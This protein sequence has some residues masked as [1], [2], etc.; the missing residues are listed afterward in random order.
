MTPAAEAAARRRA[1]EEHQLGLAPEP[2]PVRELGSAPILVSVF[3]SGAVL[4]GVEL[5]ASRVLAPFFGNSL[6][7][8]G[9]IIGV[10]LGGLSVGYWLGGVVGDLRPRPSSLLAA[11]A[12]GALTVLTIPV[13]DDPVIEQVL[14]WDPGPRLDPLLCALLLFG[15]MSIVLSAV[16]PIALRLRTQTLGRVGR[17]AGQTFAVST[18]GSIAGTFA[19]AFWLV[20]ELGTDQLFPLGAAV[21]CGTVALLAVALRAWVPLALAAAALAG[22]GAYAAWLGEERTGPLS[23]T[24]SKNWS[25][26]YRERGYG[27]LDA[28]DPGAD[29]VD[30]KLRVVFSEDTRYHRLSVVDDADTR[31]LRF[32]NS[33]QSAMWLRAPFRTRY[34]YTDFFHLGMAYNPSAR[35]VLYVGLGAGSSE[36]RLWRDFPAAQI[37]VVELDPVVVDVARRYFSLPADS[38][39]QVDVGDGRRFLAENTDRW[40]VIVIDAFFADAIPAHLVTREFLELARGRLAPGGVVVT[41]VI[42]ALDGP[43]SKLFRS[44]YKTYRTAFP[45]VLVHPAILPGDRGDSAYRNLIL[46][47]TEK[48]VPQPRALASRWDELRRAHPTAPDLRSPILDRRDAEIPTADVPVLTDDYAPTDAL[49][50]LF[51]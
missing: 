49:L 9:A 13:V 28:R 15:P 19:T 51:Q 36:K 44:V 23:A 11:L 14:A 39:L 35:R 31:Y 40:D 16:G 41:N 47:A 20:P 50:L 8:W 32:D 45:S 29:A 34:R 17:T 43:G 38:R 10:I 5:A 18:A 3:L 37:Q 4:L 1:R 21:L 7:V 30:P 48:A 22:T 24:A 26:L 33:L 25:P 2:R 42:G 27:Y 6:F 12:L 46:V